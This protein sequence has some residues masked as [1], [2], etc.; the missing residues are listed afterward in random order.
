MTGGRPV[1]PAHRLAQSLGPDLKV[2]CSGGDLG[3]E[4]HSQPESAGHA[5]GSIT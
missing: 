1:R 2:V 3:R 5:L 4:G